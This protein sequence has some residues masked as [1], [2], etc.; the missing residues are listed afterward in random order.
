MINNIEP[1]ENLRGLAI[2]K[3]RPYETKTVH[4]KLVEDALNDEW[5]ILRKNKNSVRLKRAKH[6][7]KYFEDRVWSLLYRMGFTHLSGEGG[8]I[9]LYS[10]DSESPKTQI[11]VVGLDEEIAIAIE[12]K[13]SE[14][15]GKR[16]QFSEELSK[17]ALTRE[18]FS[19]AIK[20]RFPV[21]NNR[22][23]AMVM[24]L[25]NINLTENDEARA[26][27]FKVSLFDNEDLIY[28]ENLVSQIGPAAKY[29]FFSDIL[30][31]KQIGGLRI[32]VPAIKAKMG[33]LTYYTFSVYPEYL[34]KISYVSHRAKG[35]AY[36][37]NTYQRIVNK[38]RLKSI[39]QYISDKG[40]FPTNIVINLD[41][42]FLTF[43]RAHQESEQEEAVLGW[44]D[45]KPSYKSAWIIDGQH[46]LFAYSGHENATKDRLSVLAFEGLLPSD[47]AQLFIDINSKQKNVKPSLLQELFAELNWDDKKTRVRIGAII[48][49][50][51]QIIGIDQDSPFYKRIQRAES[52]RDI[53]SCISL[54]SLFSIIDKSDFF[55]VKEKHGNIL[56]YGPLWA[57]NNDATLKRT[58]YILKNW[59]KMI[60]AN[61]KASEWWDKG[62]G[63]GG[64]LAMN[65]GV[66]ICVK[67]LRSVF[68]HLDSKGYK[69]IHM[70]NEDLFESIKE[71]GIILG[72]YFGS[73]TDDERK[74]FRRLRGIEGQTAG[75][76][77]CQK[78]IHERI[79]SFN[80][81]GLEKF[82]EEEKAQTNK[83]AKEILDRIEKQLNDI[84]LETL[85]QEFGKSE[86]EWW[87]QGVPKKVRTKVSERFEEDDGSRGEKR[88]YFDLIDYRDIIINN[89][90]LFENILSY[91]KGGKKEKRTSWIV[92]L[93]NIRQVVS[94]YTGKSVSLEELNQIQEYDVWLTAQCSG[95]ESIEYNS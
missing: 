11:D 2:A 38:S 36:D 94:H 56:E 80:P 91:G 20:V 29:Q 46:R 31:E 39:R 13:S 4:P 79:S 54:T 30:P 26:K 45:I 44:I 25:S 75:M 65:D 22:V 37:V 57:G 58:T 27:E 63:E 74:L 21:I 3:Y 24:F 55:I 95:N 32:R 66:I 69:L 12:C 87:L 23:V 49:K 90:Q 53:M 60:L 10:S 82:L 62:R 7:G 14:K 15:F 70:D 76:R 88:F 43:S 18:Y 50:S 19:Q 16:S 78:A 17:H 9:L 64:G 33:D 61:D 28:Y 77:H 1:V 83:K 35:K 47:Q 92:T 84:V 68:Q 42:K 34:L 72:D 89:W 85:Y 40:K 48:S 81:P 51:I 59:F 8:A 67:V 73:L 41:K 52:S 5:E 93:N 71:Y 6:H 86:P